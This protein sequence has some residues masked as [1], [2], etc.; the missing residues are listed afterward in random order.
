MDDLK[1]QYVEAIIKEMGFYKESVDAVIDTIFMGGGT[2]T[3]LLPEYIDKI[4]KACHHYFKVSGDCEITMESNPG[5]LTL[6][7][8]RSIKA[9]GIY[10]LSIG[11]QSWHDDELKRLGRIHT[12]AQFLDNYN[13]ARKVG[14][15]NINVD[16]MFSVPEQTIYSWKDTLD[17]VIQLAPEHISVYS[18][19]LEEHTKLQEDYYAGRLKLPDEDIDR[20]MYHM[21]TCKLSENGYNQ[22]EISNFSKK[23]YECRHN[24]KYWRCEQYIG[25]GAGAHSFYHNERFSNIFLPEDYIKQVNLGIIPIAEKTLLTEKERM[26]EYMFLGLRLT[27]G[28]NTKKFYDIFQCDVFS[29]YGKQINKFLQL[30][31]M[32]EENNYLRLTPKGMDVSN[33]VFMEFI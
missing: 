15:H 8:L 29:V 30:G 18:L 13:N 28:I 17:E 1:E 26:S 9:A 5:T 24:L 11:L 7:M 3:C 23:G 14:F 12:R 33:Q 22:Y 32:K 20:Q 2:P 31:L 27:E 21:A 4:L 10:R 6:S 19:I 25:I 16:L